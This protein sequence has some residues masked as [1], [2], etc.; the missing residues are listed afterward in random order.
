MQPLGPRIR[1][2]R[3]RLALSLDELAQRVAISKA[4]LSLIETG[5]VTNPP[6]DD[7]LRRIEEVL[8]F[9]ANELVH[10]AHLQRTPR[11]VRAMLQQLIQQR[12]QQSPVIPQGSSSPDDAGRSSSQASAKTAGPVNLDDAYLTGVLQE[13][14]E[15]T[16][17]NIEPVQG[18]AGAGAGRPAARDGAKPAL[19]MPS[20]S[21]PIVNRVSAGYP[22]DFT[23]LSYPPRNADAY[24]TAPGVDDPDV[25]A[26]R[27]SGDSMSPKYTEGDIVI[28]SPAA[29]WKEGAD[30]FVRFEDGKTTFKRVYAE[31][32]ETGRQM[33][34]LEPRN[35]RYSVRVIP[36]E[37]IAGMYRAVFCYRSVE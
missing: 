34:R 31:V 16:T 18:L 29:A 32:D 37:E 12:T 19:V 5:R 23:D 2:A 27:V 25:F 11:D 10:Q 28:F 15:R 24:I 20:H 7:K 13:L 1:R 26:A 14:A 33:L 22:S 17:S 6:S 21:A 30:C 9:A 3:R 4:Y 35:S 36:R 8:G